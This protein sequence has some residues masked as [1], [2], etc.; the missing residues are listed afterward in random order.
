MLAV[1]DDVTKALETA[2]GDGVFGKSQEADVRISAPADVAAELNRHSFATLAEAFIVNSVEVVEGGDEVA[3]EVTKAQGEA[4]PR[5][6]NIRELG[7][8]AAH[9][10][11]CKRC[12]DALDAIGADDPLNE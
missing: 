11:V 12:G 9:P 5:C 6:W 2:R 10:H 1:R 4:C 8:N 7:G 3:V